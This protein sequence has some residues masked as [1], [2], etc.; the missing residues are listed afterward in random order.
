[1]R[2]SSSP[3]RS[4][5]STKGLSRCR[6]MSRNAPPRFALHAAPLTVLPSSSKFRRLVLI[7][8]SAALLGFRDFAP[9][10]P[11]DNLCAANAEWR[12]WGDWRRDSEP[13]SGRSERPDRRRLTRH[14]RPQEPRR[15]LRSLEP[16]QAGHSLAQ[17]GQGA[18]APSG[19]PQP[20][21]NV[22]ASPPDLAQLYLQLQQ[23]DR[24][25]AMRNGCFTSTRDV[26]CARNKRSFPTRGHG[27]QGPGP[28]AR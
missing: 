22:P 24:S 21:A 11:G 10:L 5:P 14:S 2:A 28:P 15:G 12:R 26:P 4:T 17:G 1:M 16:A 8:S 13:Y 18:P 20:P 9:I 7:G 3:S 25:A 23:R 27:T 19:P 6:S